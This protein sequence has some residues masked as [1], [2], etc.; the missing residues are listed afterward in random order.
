MESSSSG[1]LHDDRKQNELCLE[2]NIADDVLPDEHFNEVD[3]QEL[4]DENENNSD[5]LVLLNYKELCRN[6]SKSLCCSICGENGNPNVGVQLSQKTLGLATTVTWTCQNGHCTSTLPDSRY[7]KY[8]KNNAKFFDVRRDSMADYNINYNLVLCMISNGLGFST[9]YKIFSTLG[10]L[11][12]GLGVRSY[13]TGWRIVQSDMSSAIDSVSKEL[14]ENNLEQEIMLTGDVEKDCEGRVPIKVSCDA[15]WQ[16]HS[17]GNRYDSGSS[18]CLM[19][20]VYS[21]KVVAYETFSNFCAKCKRCPPDLIDEMD[22]DVDVEDKPTSNDIKENEYEFQK[23]NTY[24]PKHEYC[25]LNYEGS[26]KSMETH[27]NLVLVARIFDTKKAWVETFISDDDTTTRAALKHCFKDRV[28]AG[29]ILA[30]HIPKRLTSSGRLVL[31]T[32]NGRLPLYITPPTTFLADPNHRK[33]VYGKAF[34]NLTS[35]KDVLVSKNDA[36]IMKLYYGYTQKQYK[37]ES[38]DHFKIWFKAMFQQAFNID[39]LC[40]SQWCP[41][42]NNKKL[43]DTVGVKKFK[44]IE[45]REYKVMKEIHDKHTCDELI[46]MVHHNFSSQK[47]KLLTKPFLMLRQN[48]QHFQ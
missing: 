9:M 4:D 35:S 25:P 10:I 31:I 14:V 47:M 24:L 45:S 36:E 3:H 23:I 5:V 41:Y 32:D 46:K 48:I 43:S 2:I 7:T 22:V 37:N 8:K 21:S 33:K 20:G 16:K 6:I 42:Y 30:T 18:H 11:I 12:T 40:D 13:S 34:Y 27:R 17:S 28:K 44:N 38:F 39:T 1:N 29:M 26:S 19:I 15:G